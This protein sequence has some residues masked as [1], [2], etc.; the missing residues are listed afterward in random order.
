[1]IRPPEP[2]ESFVTSE[3]TLIE[4]PQALTRYFHDST[5]QLDSY[6]PDGAVVQLRIE[7]EI[8][9]ETGLLRFHGVAFLSLH[10]AFPG[11][12]IRAYPLFA[13][14]ADLWRCNATSRDRFDGDETVYEIVSLE[15]PIHIVIAKGLEYEISEGGQ[16]SSRRRT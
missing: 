1:M 15:G 5:A 6:A 12:R 4:L 8:G 9:P 11:H 13:G 10:D 2:G 3:A 7:K 14:S 16:S